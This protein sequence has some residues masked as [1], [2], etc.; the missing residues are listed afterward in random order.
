MGEAEVFLEEQLAELCS[1]AGHSSELLQAAV[2][3]Q[4]S[5]LSHVAGERTSFCLCLRH[6]DAALCRGPAAAHHRSGWH[7]PRWSWQTQTARAATSATTPHCYPSSSSSSSSCLKRSTRSSP[8]GNTSFPGDLG[9]CLDA[10]TF[11]VPLR[12]SLPWSITLFVY[13]IYPSAPCDVKRGNEVVS[14]FQQ[15]L[16]SIGSFLLAFLAEVRRSLLSCLHT[17]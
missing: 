12:A 13:W 6:L 17:L 4:I 2:L 7:K 14:F 5:V 15:W 11:A 10:C 1:R 9:I 16:Q 8:V 3:R